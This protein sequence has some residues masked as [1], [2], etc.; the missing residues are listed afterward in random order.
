MA[1][2][3]SATK[4]F[5][6]TMAAVV[7]FLATALVVSGIAISLPIPEKFQWFVLG[8]SAWPILTLWMKAYRSNFPSEEKP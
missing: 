3:V 5:W 2:A 7:G 8:A 4:A 1:E 6:M